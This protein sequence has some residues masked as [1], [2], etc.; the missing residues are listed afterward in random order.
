MLNPSDILFNEFSIKYVTYSY[1][2]GLLN[3]MQIIMMASIVSLISMIVSLAIGIR[4][5][6]CL[7]IFVTNI[8]DKTVSIFLYQILC[9]LLYLDDFF[10][11]VLFF[12]V[13]VVVEGIIYKK[14]LKYK[15]YNGM[16]VSVICNIGTAVITILMYNI[17]AYRLRSLW[18]FLF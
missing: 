8:V 12:L 5:K 11:A 15:K 3:I 16:T 7:A 2:E 9:D 14:V 4:K 17:F 6:D 13:T 10:I 18:N 1:K